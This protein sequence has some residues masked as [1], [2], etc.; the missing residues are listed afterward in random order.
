MMFP[1]Q[2][3]WEKIKPRE[4]KSITDT[5]KIETPGGSYR[6]EVGKISEL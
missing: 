3:R 4:K 5:E 2:L 1:K 6:T